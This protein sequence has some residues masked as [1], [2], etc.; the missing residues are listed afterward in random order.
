M[1]KK[2]KKKINSQMF[3]HPFCL[4]MDTWAVGNRKDHNWVSATGSGSC[5]HTPSQDLGSIIKRFVR[6]CSD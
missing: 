5:I 4:S 6:F 1:T 3:V 2:K